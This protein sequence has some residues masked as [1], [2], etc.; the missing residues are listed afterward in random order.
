[1]YVSELTV[2]YGQLRQD[3]KLFCW[4]QHIVSIEDEE[5][6]SYGPE[7]DTLTLNPNDA[8]YMCV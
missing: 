5:G 1:M 2:L 3:E 6:T 7:A 8:I 4:R